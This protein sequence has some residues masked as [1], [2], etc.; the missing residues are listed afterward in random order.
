MSFLSFGGKHAKASLRQKLAQK[1]SSCDTVETQPPL[2]CSPKKQFVPEPKETAVAATSAVLPVKAPVIAKTVPDRIGLVP[3]CDCTLFEPIVLDDVLVYPSKTKEELFRW[4]RTRLSHPSK[5][6][7]SIVF[8]RGPTGSCK[9][10][11]VRVAARTCGVPCEEP[12]CFRLRDIIDAL[13]KNV[14]TRAL[15][16]DRTRVVEKRV[17]LFSGLDGWLSSAAGDTAAADVLDFYD[18]LST[19]NAMGTSC[20][21]IVFTA[22]SSDHARMRE[23][24]GLSCVLKLFS[25][26]LDFKK[27]RVFQ[28]VSVVARRVC[29]VANVS[30]S[31]ADIAMAAFDGDM[32]RLMTL[33]EMSSRGL[34]GDTTCPS[35]SLVSKDEVLVLNLND[36]FQ[37][38]KFILQPTSVLS[39]DALGV[40]FDKFSLLGGL[41]RENAC[42]GMKNVS[43]NVDEL[44]DIAEIWSTIDVC[45]TTYWQHPALADSMHLAAVKKL[46]DYRTRSGWSDSG[47]MLQLPLKSEPNKE[48]L[49]DACFALSKPLVRS[50][51]ASGLALIEQ[52]E[53]LNLKKNASSA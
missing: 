4:M 1:R 23:L 40:L 41:L 2:V 30:T 21:P 27:S 14:C 8:I 7:R 17:W 53:V 24:R 48:L 15:C 52:L 50:P 36:A 9:R 19:L 51:C 33:L 16:L 34:L 42:L 43:D 5:E 18:L 6:S 38:C 20:P 28:E 12:S 39:A 46:R 44:A 3:W 35:S 22:V 29:V 32:K 26:A 11:L 45:D 13:S 31:F 10:T 47:G 37:A 49:Q 25:N